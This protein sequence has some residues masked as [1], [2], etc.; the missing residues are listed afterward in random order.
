MHP[1]VAAYRSDEFKAI[2]EQLGRGARLDIAA[3]FDFDKDYGM[4]EA[5]A[6]SMGGP[7]ETKIYEGIGHQLMLF[8][9][10]D[11]SKDVHAFCL[12]NI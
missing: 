5:M 2:I 8:H 4:F 3:W 1:A 6:A 7:V 11:Y 10:K 12:D 9:T